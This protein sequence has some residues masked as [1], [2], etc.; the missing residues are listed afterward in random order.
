MGTD[1]LF[2]SSCQFSS[3]SSQTPDRLTVS[4]ASM[5]PATS[6][7]ARNPEEAP[8]SGERSC[9]PRPGRSVDEMMHVRCLAPF[10]PC[11]M[12]YSYPPGFRIANTVPGRLMPGIDTHTHRR[13]RLDLVFLGNIETRK[14]R[15]AYFPP[16]TGPGSGDDSKREKREESAGCRRW[17]PKQE[18][19]LS[20]NPS[21]R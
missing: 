11:P 20:E 2:F 4:L 15:R 8:R 12:P 10:T 7:R 18:G 21:T 5:P 14:L 1:Q 17:E 16:R 13:A 19:G 3:V 9:S 6:H